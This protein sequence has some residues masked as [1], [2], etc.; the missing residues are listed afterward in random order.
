[1]ESESDKVGKWTLKATCHGESLV[2][3]WVC[4]HLDWLSPAFCTGIVY[5]SPLRGGL[6]ALGVIEIWIGIKSKYYHPPHT[7]RKRLEGPKRKSSREGGG[8]HT[9]DQGSIPSISHGPLSPCKS[10]S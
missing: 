8:L 5:G 4:L 9:T 2:F 10:N 6:D 7:K 1:M 3:I